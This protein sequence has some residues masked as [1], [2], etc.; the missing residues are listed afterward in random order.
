MA[1]L[2]SGRTWTSNSST[3]MYSRRSR[4]QRSRPYRLARNQA[5]SD[6]RLADSGRRV[7]A[8]ASEPWQTFRG[9]DAESLPPDHMGCRGDRAYRDHLRRAPESRPASILLLPPGRSLGLGLSPDTGCVC[10]RHHARRGRLGLGSIRCSSTHAVA[11]LRYRLGH[12]RGVGLTFNAGRRA[13]AGLRAVSPSLVVVAGG[14]ADA[15][16]IRVHGGM[17]P[18][19]ISKGN[20]ANG[21][22]DTM[23]VRPRS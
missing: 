7:L 15:C 20:E 13:C 18:P 23:K 14:P 12:S 11:S 21:R 17:P 3:Q 10:V 22:S 9:N 6:Q 4:R 2:A 19:N 16:R 8:S 5:C 1:T